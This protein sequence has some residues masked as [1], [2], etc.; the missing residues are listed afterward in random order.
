MLSKNRE[1]F[2][3]DLENTP[4]A[5]ILLAQKGRLL[6]NSVSSPSHYL[7]VLIAGQ[8]S[9]HPNTA[10]SRQ[11]INSQSR[12]HVVSR[13]GD[14]M[15]QLSVLTDAFSPIFYACDQNSVLLRIHKSDI[16]K[17]IGSKETTLPVCYKLVES[18]AER[19]NVALHRVEASIDWSMRKG[20]S[21]VYKEGDSSRRGFYLVLSGRVLVSNANSV[22]QG[23][24]GNGQ[25]QANIGGQA[26]GA[27]SGLKNESH[28]QKIIT[29]GGITGTRRCVIRDRHEL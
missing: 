17:L 14:L 7:Y 5:D 28:D 1:K 11:N 22:V 16:S 10:T 18:L 19:A 24:G 29:R 3:G 20:G 12:A 15:G 25:R 21:V 27:G 4:K 23:G 9:A 13:C 6:C 2:E 8:C 26:G